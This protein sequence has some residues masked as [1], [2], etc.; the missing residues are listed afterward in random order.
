MKMDNSKTVK[1]QSKISYEELVQKSY[2]MLCLKCFKPQFEFKKI[3]QETLSYEE[4]QNIFCH[5]IVFDV[6]EQK[7]KMLIVLKSKG[8][9]Y[10]EKYQEIFNKSFRNDIFLNLLDQYFLDTDQLF[11]IYEMEYCNMTLLQ[12]INLYKL[13]SNIF[14]PL[15]KEIGQYITSQFYEND[16][17]HCNIS[18]FYVNVINSNKIEVKI[19]LIHENKRSNSYFTNNKVSH[20][21]KDELQIENDSNELELEQTVFQDLADSEK[22]KGILKDLCEQVNVKIKKNDLSDLIQDKFSKILQFHQLEIFSIIQQHPLYDAFE[23]KRLDNNYFELIVQKRGQKIRLIAEKFNQIS[24]AEQVITKHQYLIENKKQLCS[25]FIQSEIIT[26]E[27]GFYILAEKISIQDDQISVYD[28]KCAPISQLIQFCYNLLINNGLSI[29]NIPPSSLLVK[30]QKNQQSQDIFDFYIDD[31]SLSDYS[32]EYCE[33][34]LDCIFNQYDC[35]KVGLTNHRG[36]LNNLAKTFFQKINEKSL[37]EVSSLYNYMQ[38]LIENNDLLL[39]SDLKIKISKKHMNQI[40]VNLDQCTSLDSVLNLQ[41]KNQFFKITNLKLE[42]DSFKIKQK[43][44]L[45]M[46]NDNPEENSFYKYLKE[47]VKELNTFFSTYESD[48]IK[49]YSKQLSE[50]L[51]KQTGELKIEFNVQ[52]FSQDQTIQKMKHEQQNEDKEQNLENY[53][54]ADLLTNFRQQNIINLA[55]GNIDLKQQ[56]FNI[57][58]IIN[59]NELHQKEINFLQHYQF[60]ILNIKLSRFSDPLAIKILIFDDNMYYLIGKGPYIIFNLQEF[61]SFK[62]PFEAQLH[63]EQGLN[64]FGS[65]YI[66][67]YKQNRNIT[68]GAK[69][70]SEFTHLQQLS[71]IINNYEAQQFDLSGCQQIQQLNIIL[72]FYLGGNSQKYNLKNIIKQIDSTNCNKL[73]FIYVF[74]GNLYNNFSK[75]QVNLSQIYKIKRLVTVSFA[76]KLGWYDGDSKGNFNSERANEEIQELQWDFDNSINS[77]KSNKI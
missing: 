35:D 14:D 56:D 40:S 32:S 69:F 7:K 34:F 55:A 22:I 72:G 10:L 68:I 47:N 58:H 27:T 74:N 59:L 12:F 52:N 8:I 50:F 48:F 18:Q 5:V 30:T 45:G 33:I 13:D 73:K 42:D 25:N 23:I 36:M 57:S 70:I 31:I 6:K 53:T 61:Q 75:D 28:L 15:L 16:T 54:Q 11:Y 51:L 63:L 67:E 37:Q 38:S 21:D 9:E 26:V 64:I 44:I 60:A 41:N 1:K 29:N 3:V 24:K 77:I 49:Y 2:L 62:E 17:Y 4:N 71:L 65:S 43:Y 19:N 20:K 39:K 76:K 46:I 66:N